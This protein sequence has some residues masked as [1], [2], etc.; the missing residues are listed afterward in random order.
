MSIR[1]GRKEM[2]VLLVAISLAA[3]SASA[4]SAV[5]VGKAA[6]ATGRVIVGHNNDGPG[7]FVFRQALVPARDGRAAMFWSEVKATSGGPYAGDHFLNEYGV[8]IVSN[9]AGIMDEWDGVRASP[10][11]SAA[12]ISMPPAEI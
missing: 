9:G 11:A 12:A 7:P 1:Y 6:S 3:A 4:C 10:S 8:L 2:R 5:I